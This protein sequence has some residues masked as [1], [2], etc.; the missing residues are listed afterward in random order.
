MVYLKKK[1]EPP[2]P[3]DRKTNQYIPFSLIYICLNSQPAQLFSQNYY[4]KNA[5]YRNLTTIH[6]KWV[7]SEKVLLNFN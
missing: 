6:R 1:N 4:N 2:C 5:I 3:F 7:V